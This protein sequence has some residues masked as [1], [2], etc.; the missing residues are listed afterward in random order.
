MSSI[1]TVTDESK[2]QP[3]GNI[4][5][6]TD[7]SRLQPLPSDDLIF[8][9]DSSAAPL[10]RGA[11]NS[12]QALNVLQATALKDVPFFGQDIAG[13]ARDIADAERDKMRFAADD[14]TIAGLN[15]ISSAENFGDAVVA[16]LTNPKAVGS[17]VAESLVTSLPSIGLAGLGALSV[18]TPAAPVAPLVI[19]AGAGGGS[20]STEFGL[21]VLEFAREQGINISDPVELEEFLSDPEVSAEATEFA[22]NR[23][24]GVGIFDALS[25]GTAGRITRPVRALKRGAGRGEMALR[26]LGETFAQAGFGGAGEATAQKLSGQEFSPGD[27]TLEA[28]AEIIPG[29]GEIAIGS[30]TQPTATGNINTETDEKNLQPLDGINVETEESNLQPITEAETDSDLQPLNTQPIPDDT[31]NEISKGTAT[32]SSVLDSLSKTVQDVDSNN[33]ISGIRK[34]ARNKLGLQ[35]AVKFITQEEANRAFGLK[36]GE[37]NAAGFYDV[38]S[39]TVFL[40]PVG[41]NLEVS[42]H[43]FVHALTSQELPESIRTQTENLSPVQYLENLEA[44]RNDKTVSEPIRN[45][46]DSFLQARIALNASEALNVPGGNENALSNIDE[47]LAELF[48][49]VEFQNQLAGIKVEGTEK[50]LFQKIVDAIKGLIGGKDISNTLLEKALNEGAAVMKRKG[51]PSQQTPNAK[52]RQKID[53]RTPSEEDQASIRE[54]L[55]SDQATRLE[56]EAA[57]G[58]T[59]GRAGEVA[60]KLTEQEAEKRS[61][62]APPISKSR[63]KQIERARQGKRNNKGKPKKKLV[64]FP[65][66]DEKPKTTKAMQGMTD[67]V[68]NDPTLRPYQEPTEAPLILKSPEV[69]PGILDDNDAQGPQNVGRIE[70]AKKDIKDSGDLI[71]VQPAV[72]KAKRGFT[73]MVKN[74]IVRTADGGTI[75]ARGIHSMFFATSS[76]MNWHI[77]RA[78]KKHG[79]KEGADLMR[80]NFNL[81]SVGTDFNEGNGIEREAQIVANVFGA[82]L[83][84]VLAKNKF[85]KGVK[86]MLTAEQNAAVRQAIIEGKKIE[87]EPGL[88]ELVNTI[89]KIYTAMRDHINKAT[90]EAYNKKINL[91]LNELR[92]VMGN[93]FTVV[94][95]RMNRNLWKIGALEDKLSPDAMRI[96]KEIAADMDTLAKLRKQ[97]GR[98]SERQGLETELKKLYE[99]AAPIGFVENYFQRIY[100]TQKVQDGQKEFVDQ[101]TKMYEELQTDL[102]NRIQS[103][104]DAQQGQP[105]PD[106]DIEMDQAKNLNPAEQAMELWKTL[107]FDNNNDFEMAS[108]SNFLKTRS[109]P[110]LVVEKYLSDFMDTDPVRIVKEYIGKASLHAEQVRAFGKNGEFMLD[111]LNAMKAAGVPDDEA[112]EFFKAVRVAAGMGKGNPN[113]PSAVNATLGWFN[114][115]MIVTLLT[116]ASFNAMGEPLNVGIR[117]GSAKDS[118]LALGGSMKALLGRGDS[119]EWAS[120]FESLGII[121]AGMDQITFTNKYNDVFDSPGRQRLANR[122]FQI[123]GMAALDRASRISAGVRGHAFLMASIRG[124][125]KLNKINLSSLGIPESEMDGFKNWLASQDTIPDLQNIG[126]SKYGK[127]Y[128]TAIARF[129]DQ[130]I[131]NPKATDKPMLANNPVGKIIFG[132]TS[133]A[134]A[135]QK[136]ILGLVG[137]RVI[138]AARGKI[139]GEELN[140]SERA[141]MAMISILPVMT[142]YAGVAAIAMVREGLADEDRLEEMMENGQF[143]SMAASR[144]GFF[145]AADNLVQAWSGLKYRRDLSNSIIGA[146]TGYTLQSLGDIMRGVQ[147][148]NEGE[149]T[150]R[151]NQKILEGIYKI[152]VAPAIVTGT[153]ALPQTKLLDPAIGLF[154]ALFATAPKTRKAIAESLTE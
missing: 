120:L 133:F 55:D 25:G 108:G 52:R 110:P 109:L 136:N 118:L 29:L 80:K 62:D 102:V 27:I 85:I 147:A 154:N 106:L 45:L 28:I 5:V 2:L 46:V 44:V 63:Q 49:N 128:S 23:A 54:E 89:R 37:G 21:S 64:K 68:Y 76:V 41:E 105:T 93:E 39:N 12:R 71:H 38:D 124:H 88:N 36:E 35:A 81:T 112:R 24:I 98:S 117:T 79:S 91:K 30:A 99:R 114:T 50:N 101:A 111:D 131:Q 90:L 43:E 122:A 33:L 150:E 40:S 58:V 141:A 86:S 10:M 75:L 143:W 7:E 4:P 135:Y 69:Q 59:E 48:S 47:F 123:S 126:D 60:D 87:G 16:A 18:F 104:I 26:G 153:A 138:A 6:V 129:I 140:A 149:S 74:G 134:Y 137:K 66:Q 73:E 78:E 116:R 42:I 56:E 84:R 13:A 19:A 127:M 121:A 20:A 119:K 3:I 53:R 100:D 92:R 34:I 65:V 70:N 9:E 103:D 22:K 125:S 14:D 51:K 17:T 1:R 61:K 72:N 144:A 146:S 132:L 83:Q 95:N 67:R 115:V 97:K 94:F 31:R 82:A 11:A 148:I 139:H 152:T 8:V 77:R 151:S 32:V 57:A 130:T 96:R 145:G 15:E 142:T 113:L 107:T